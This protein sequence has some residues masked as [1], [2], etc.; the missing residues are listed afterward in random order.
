MRADRNLLGRTSFDGLD[1]PG[2]FVPAIS[3]SKG[4][5]A[6]C[7][8]TSLGTLPHVNGFSGATWKEPKCETEISI[9]G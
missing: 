3:D 1:Q 4:C 8:G 5:H 2:Y 9:T 6:I 7:A